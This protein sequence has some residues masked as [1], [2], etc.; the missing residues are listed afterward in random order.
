MRH[1][2]RSLA[3]V[4]RGALWLLRAGGLRADVDR[5]LRREQRRR[6]LEAGD[7]RGYEH[8]VFSQNGEDGI[9]R[10]ILQRVG[11]PRRHFVEFGVESGAECNCARLAREEGW[12]GLFLE[13]DAEHFAKLAAN[14][15]AY[16]I[17]R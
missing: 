1:S 13:A 7:L 17:G 3:S 9:V 12:A 4:A 8:R 16:Q 11:A 5:L 14:Y 10:E 6:W 15:R 2:L